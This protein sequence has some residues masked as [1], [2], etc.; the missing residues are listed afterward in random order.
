MLGRLPSVVDS[1]A[2]A[3]GL[4]TFVPAYRQIEPRSMSRSWLAATS[5]TH[6]GTAPG[7]SPSIEPATA[8]WYALSSGGSHGA[9]AGLIGSRVAVQD[10]RHRARR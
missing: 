1:M 9:T 8:A 5:A 6:A 4:I 3:R 2:R 7:S 10:E